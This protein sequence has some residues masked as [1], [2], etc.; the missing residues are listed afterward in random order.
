MNFELMEK[1]IILN[2]DKGKCLLLGTGDNITD[3]FDP[4]L[5]G[6]TCFCIALSEFNNDLNLIFST[7]EKVLY[8][9]TYQLVFNLEYINKLKLS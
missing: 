1:R 8:A 5:K 3:P 9:H 2:S 6:I 4:S 7:S